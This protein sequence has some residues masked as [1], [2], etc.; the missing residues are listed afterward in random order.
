MGFVGTA[1]DNSVDRFGLSHLMNTC[2]DEKKNP[3]ALKMR[4]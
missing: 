3:I 1:E 4:V 2:Y